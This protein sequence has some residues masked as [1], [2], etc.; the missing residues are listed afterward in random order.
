MHCPECG[1]EILAGSE[2][3]GNCGAPVTRQQAGP[4]CANCG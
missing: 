4:V 2:F 3:C 1:Q